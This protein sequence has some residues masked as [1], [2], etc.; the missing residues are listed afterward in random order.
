M[1]DGDKRDSG[2]QLGNTGADRA[3][4]L[5]R[6]ITGAIPVVG[7][8]LSEIVTV[9]VPNQR[10]DRLEKYLVHL[11]GEIARLR[12]PEERLKT[13]ESVDLI[14]DG[15]YQAVRA[16]TDDR[17]RY[18]ARCVSEGV[19]DDTRTHIEKK[20]ILDL[21]DQ[22]DDQE[23]LILDAFG[24]PVHDRKTKFDA[25]KPDVP[26]IG[27]T[28][29]QSKQMTVYSAAFDKLERLALITQQPVMNQQ[30]KKDY[31]LTLPEFDFF[32]R[33]RGAHEITSLGR[34]LLDRVGL[35]Q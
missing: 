10:I 8:A 33:P 21:L 32:G 31:G 25:L 35:G 7:A 17:R 13:T 27:V 9:I 15:A 12:I 11:E 23:L 19:S 30:A 24:S 16:L 5:V 3:V 20:R 2:Q 6:S 1:D 29:A 22:L 34:M 28:E 26:N 14:E 18:I 4:A